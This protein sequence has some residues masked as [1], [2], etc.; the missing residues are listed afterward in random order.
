[1]S[2]SPAA[3]ISSSSGS[4]T[5][6]RSASTAAAAQDVLERFALTDAGDR[7][8]G[9]YSGGMR[10]R[11]DIGA[12]LIAVR[13]CC[14]STSRRPVLIRVPRNDVLALHRGTCRRRHDDPADDPVHGGGRAACAPDRR[15]RPRQ[16]DRQGTAPELKAQLGGAML[17][18]GDRSERPRSSR[19]L[20]REVGGSPPRIDRDQ[21]LVAIPTPGGTALLLAAGRRF[22][23]ST[24]RSMTSASGAPRS[25]TSSSR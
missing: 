16:R 25:T 4:G 17:R 13:P 12:S 5:T 14:S 2:C 22:E 9:R 8:S 10:R 6:S 15:H 11:L 18:R 1:M 3:R 21:Q 19:R 23:S 7:R 20:A 24:S